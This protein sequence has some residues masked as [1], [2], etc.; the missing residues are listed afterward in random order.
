MLFVGMC[1][2]VALGLIV[3]FWSSLPFL[4]T[5]LTDNPSA[6]EISTYNMFAFPLAILISLFLT[7]SPLVK[8]SDHEVTGHKFV[9]PTAIIVGLIIS[10][11]LY[12]V[13]V[14]EM[15][16]AVTLF[17]YFFSV[18]LYLR[19]GLNPGKLLA[20]LVSGIVAVI[21]AILLNVKD[22][23]YLF[24]I[25]SATAAISAQI[26]ALA[27]HLPDNLKAAGGSISHLGYGLM[28]LGILASSAFGSNEQL[29]LARGETNTLNEY[30]Y[31]YHGLSGSIMQKN[32]EIL[33]TMIKGDRETEARPHYFY[34]RRM[35]AIMKRPHIEK[36][37]LY[38]LYLSP[39][40]IQELPH[41]HGLVLGKGEMRVV[42]DYSI[43]FVRF[44]IASHSL[45]AGSAMSVGA[46]LEVSKDSIVE[47]T[48]PRMETGGGG[49][50]PTGVALYSDGKYRVML[51][52]IDA[53]N[54][55]ISLSIPGLIEAGPP[56]RLIMDISYKPGINLLWV[57]TLIVFLG[58][59]LSTYR[60]L[61]K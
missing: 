49:K 2:M 22:I 5:Y 19:P 27:K 50:I 42:G 61:K 54:G 40:E 4:T 41:A 13:D 28:L 34:T 7:L 39:Q 23:S 55:L 37:L 53:D 6:A 36:N 15:T 8:K 10:G 60:R 48:I 29:V 20:A 45:D 32:N 51:E 46:V 43:K 44:D 14:V 47:T 3:L 33:L 1:L 57:G 38:D 18:I 59:G 56:D 11:I 52:K 24:F 17:I 12:I 26:T 16:V 35:D 25:G 21:F 30:G 31:R 9:A 58:L